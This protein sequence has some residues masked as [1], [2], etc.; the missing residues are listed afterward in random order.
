MTFYPCGCVYAGGSPLCVIHERGGLT[1]VPKSSPIP[2]KIIWLWAIVA[3]VVFALGIG[4][5][6]ASG[7]DAFPLKPP[8]RWYP[9]PHLQDGYWEHV[10]LPHED[11]RPR[12]GWYFWTWPGSKNNAVRP[13]VP[14]HGMKWV[15]RTWVAEG[16]MP[17][18]PP[19]PWMTD[20]PYWVWSGINKRWERAPDP[21]GIHPWNL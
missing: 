8:Y 1:V 15:E 21:P 3:V 13:R 7:V 11:G 12:Y 19:P 16:I 17:G 20:N 18:D 14:S 9:T 2:F 5:G 10:V 4:I 6:R